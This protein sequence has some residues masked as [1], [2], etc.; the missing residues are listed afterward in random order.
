M[1]L[2][3]PPV[4]TKKKPISVIFNEKQLDDNSCRNIISH[5]L[6][7]PTQKENQI[8]TNSQFNCF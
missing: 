2:F 8:A 5:M 7:E 4:R 6:N 3:S 1:F